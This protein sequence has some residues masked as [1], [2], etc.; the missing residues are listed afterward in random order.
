LAVLLLLQFIRP[1]KNK[2]NPPYPVDIT[3]VYPV[4]ADVQV[5]LKNACYDCHS[6]NTGYPWYNNVQPVGLY[7]DHHVKE[8]KHEL[9]FN[10]FAIYPAKRQRHKLEEIAEQVKEGEMPLRSYTLLHAEAR[11]TDADK[12]TILKW[13]E[14]VLSATPKN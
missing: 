10:E 11:L 7:L 13:V 12:A 1:A 6:N 4:P 14:T 8:G 5:I 2:S 9:N 3:T